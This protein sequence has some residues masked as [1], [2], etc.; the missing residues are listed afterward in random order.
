MP[1]EGVCTVPSG[2]E[3]MPLTSDVDALKAKIN[4]LSASGGT[5][6]HLGTA[7]AW[8]TLSPN[9]A[10]LWPTAEPAGGLRRRRT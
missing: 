2:S 7:W 3:V 5:A 8:Y 4:G 9:W 10:S 6:G 1:P